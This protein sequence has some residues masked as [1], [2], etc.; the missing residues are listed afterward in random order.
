MDRRYYIMIGTIAA[1]FC[2]CSFFLGI[3]AKNVVHRVSMRQQQENM[4][5]KEQ[6]KKEAAPE[7]ADDVVLAGY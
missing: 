2:L 4:A 5:L 1:I 3:D 7:T 6:L